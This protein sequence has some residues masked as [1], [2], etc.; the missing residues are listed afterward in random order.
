MLEVILIALYAVLISVWIYR[1]KTWAQFDIRPQWI[2]LLFLL[3]SLMGIIYGAIYFEF[4]Q[5]GDVVHYFQDSKIIFSAFYK[6]P[7]HY[8]QL[9]F[10]THPSGEVPPSL[11]YLYDQMRLSW[12]TP[13]Y[14]PV[15]IHS[16]L[17]AFSQ[18]HFYVNTLLFNVLSVWG[19]CRLYQFFRDFGKLNRSFVFIV[20]F[21][22]PASLFW[23]SGIH[24]DGITL[25]SL[26][27][28]LYNNLRILEANKGQR[29]SLLELLL[30]VALLAMCRSY[31]LMLLVPFLFVM[32][33]LQRR[34][35]QSFKTALTV[36]IL[37]LLVLALMMQFSAGM[38]GPNIFQKL[39]FEQQF[40]LQ[41]K[42]NTHLPM[43]DSGSNLQEMTRAVPQALKHVFWSPISYPPVHFYQHLS[44]YASILELLLICLLLYSIIM[45]RGQLMHK[46]HIRVFSFFFA[47]MVLLL[48]GLTVPALGAIVR[49]KAV[50][51]P[52]LLFAIG[53]SQNLESLFSRK[54][55]IK[56]FGDNNLH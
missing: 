31:L 30:G 7:W 38:G 10:G 36:N 15:R 23:C 40:L 9:T 3:K 34:N 39:Q 24:K 42:G 53:P 22:L 6:N 20:V 4:Y 43:Q 35:V 8:L 54:L 28:I 47:M 50:A 33:V 11:S 46:A 16:I 56:L 55:E 37:T 18:G 29:G 12:R 25:L 45:N 49:Y 19:L 32:L 2:V 21:L 44:R 52:F 26:G 48:I 41:L 17:N 1:S 27:L 5:T 14:L 51:I 13:E